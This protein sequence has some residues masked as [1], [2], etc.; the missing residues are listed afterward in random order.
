[1]AKL[2]L[3]TGNRGKVREFEALLRGVPYEIVTPEQAHI[4]TQVEE[5]GKTYAD[6]ARIKAVTLCQESGL[7][8][9]ADDSGIE[10][11]ALDGEPGIHSARY[12]GEGLSDRDRVNLLLEKLKNVPLEK[13]TA[14]FVSVITIAVP[15]GDVY[16]ARG[17]CEGIIAFEPKGDKGFGYDPVFY[18]QELGKTMAELDMETKNRISHRGKAAIKAREILARLAKNQNS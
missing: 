7:I 6:N 13:R 18:F 14:R 1:M 15:N 11:D 5:S 10:V 9:L 16:Y 3:A 4:S 17:V 2:L 8:T 12:G